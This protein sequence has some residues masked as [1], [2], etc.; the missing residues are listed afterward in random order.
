[1]KNYEEAK[2]EA[3]RVIDRYYGGDKMGCCIIEYK[4][5]RN[6][7]KTRWGFIFHAEDSNGEW[8][9]RDGIYERRYAL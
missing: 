7:R 8:V 6:S 4:P 9:E 3:K 1:M 5:R 2:Q